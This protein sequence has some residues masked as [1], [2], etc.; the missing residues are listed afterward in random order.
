MGSQCLKEVEL[1]AKENFDAQEVIGWTDSNVSSGDCAV[2]KAGDIVHFKGSQNPLNKW[3][4]KSPEK[5]NSDLKVV[6]ACRLSVPHKL[7]LNSVC[8]LSNIR[9]CWAMT[10]LEQDS[11]LLS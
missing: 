9:C 4:I 7:G 1:L 6:D 2:H 8:H 3:P 5:V 11:G 10:R